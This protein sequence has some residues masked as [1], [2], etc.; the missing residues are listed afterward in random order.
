MVK[1]FRKQ[2]KL[3]KKN[4]YV[5]EELRNQYFGYIPLVIVDEALIS[6]RLTLS[7]IFF[8]FCKRKATL[9][10]DFWMIDLKLPV[11][12][13]VTF[14]PYWTSTPEIHTSY[15]STFHRES[16]N[17]NAFCTSKILGQGYVFR[18]VPSRWISLQND[19]LVDSSLLSISKY[20][21]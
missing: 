19:W 7:A 12:S 17:P 10:Y 16:P 8:Q 13:H 18:F 21:M 4:W 9:L 5:I 3:F 11:F 14:I 20:F 2:A 15:M 6:Y 1:V